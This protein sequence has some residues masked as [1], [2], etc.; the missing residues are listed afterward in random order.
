MGVQAGSR[1]MGYSCQRTHVRLLSVVIVWD[2]LETLHFSQPFYIGILR[3]ESYNMTINTAPMVKTIEISQ[4]PLRMRGGGDAETT[5]DDSTY[6]KHAADI[7]GISVA[8]LNLITSTK[9]YK[10]SKN[11]VIMCII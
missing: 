2:I 3:F 1:G 4:N 6:T 7:D 10:K 5:L 8:T 11:T 9:H